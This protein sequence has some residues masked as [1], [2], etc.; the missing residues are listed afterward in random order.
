MLESS[1]QTPAHQT[2]EELIAFPD[3]WGRQLQRTPNHVAVVSAAGQ[4]T[5]RDLDHQSNA[6]ARALVSVGIQHGDRVGLCVDRSPEAIAAMLGIMKLG[7][8]FVPLDPDYPVDRLRYMVDDA[9]ITT[10]VG[11]R[12]YYES[13]GVP[14]I[15]Q[16]AAH[17]S[18][19][20][21]ICWVDC[22]PDQSDSNALG[23]NV[24]AARPSVSIAPSDLAYIMYTSGSTGKPKGVQI[25]HSA[26]ATY[27][28]A[29]IDVFRLT[30]NDRTLQFS[31][32]CFDIAIE[33]IFPP[34]LSGG[35]VV[36]RPKER[37]SHRNELSTLIDRFEITAVHIAA[38][39]WHQWVDLMVA[40]KERVPESLR[41]IIPTGEKVSVE[42][43]RRWQSICDH[44]VLFCNAYG[45]T[46]A[47]VTSTVYIPDESFDAANM[48]IG[49][50]LKRYTAHIL[51]NNLQPVAEG[52]TGHLFI[53]GPALALG[54]LNR[55]DLTAAAFVNV[56]IDGEK[57][58]LYR[59]GD[60]ARW[61]PDGN[62]DF[63]GRV[64]HQIKLGSYRIEPGEI[65]AA[66]DQAP[67]VLGSLVSFDEVDGK[68]FLVAY[69]AHG[70]HEVSANTIAT[71]LRSVLP[72]YMVPAR[73]VFL[74]K[75]PH[76]I[77]G[78]IDRR[79]LPPASEGVVARDESY[80]PPR[81]NLE[82]R[83]VELWQEVLNVPE[84]GI[85][86][87]FFLLGG[88]SL[89]VTQVVA[90]LTSDMD[91]DL[92]VRDFFANPTVASSARHLRELLGETTESY[93][94]DDIR[95]LRDR[96]PDVQASFFQSNGQS[97]YGVHYRPRGNKLGRGVV[98]CH[99][100]GHEY[101]RGYRNLQQ[102]AIQLCSAGFDVLRFDYASTGNSDGACAE[103]T[104]AEMQCNL[105]NARDFLIQQS[106]AEQIAVI[107]LRLGATIA[108]SMADGSFDQV[109]LWDPIVDVSEFIGTMD[110]WHRRQ[111]TELRRFS[112]IRVASDVDQSYGHAM[113]SEKRQ[114]LA[115]LQMPATGKNVSVVVSDQSL[116]SPVEQT[117]LASQTN[118]TRVA[119]VI[120]WD[121]Q[122][123]TESAFSSPESA[124]AI[125]RVLQREQG[126]GEASAA[127]R[128]AR[129]QTQP[130]QPELANPSPSD[131]K[132][133]IVFGNYDHLLGV[134]QPSTTTRHSD[135]AVILVTPGMLHH[136]GPFRLYVDVANDL[137][138]RGI[139]S[140][141]FDISGIGE[142][143]GVGAG[144][145]SIDR[146][147]DEISQAID[148][149]S[150]N[151]QLQKIVL[152]GLC[153]GA[154]DSLHAAV[155][156]D[157]VSAVVPMD[158]CGYRTRAYY[159][160][161][162]R[163]HHFHRILRPKKWWEVLQRLLNQDNTAPPSLQPGDDI[164]EFPSRETAVAE[165]SEL[166]DRKTRLHFVY[167][168]GVG[169]YY[170]YAQQFHDMFPELRGRDEVS[171]CFHPA[172][173][174]V[175][176]L[177]ED[178]ARLV[179]HIGSQIDQMAAH[180]GL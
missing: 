142:S 140:L 149:I 131:S 57:L 39:Y 155:R 52:E 15:D 119:D 64:D 83:L 170:S 98:I 145:R 66:I 176:Y 60:L 90:R 82:K 162:F 33:E 50:P 81:D 126:D 172:M 22:V 29:D 87:D 159:W 164:R 31:T 43:Y 146:A 12:C 35:C 95:A 51:D 59:T 92:P 157:R 128:P 118:V 25:Q 71:F 3:L 104:A 111:L 163:G 136:V 121:A 21:N 171:T 67:G 79:A 125:L 138:R 124:K 6:V 65:E 41:L 108:A 74:D 70:K 112:T 18:T 96:L 77:N 45:P 173:D 32:L 19:P 73:F 5:Y 99:S 38:A 80:V 106:G 42:H 85:H 102:L 94:D 36:V 156:D 113:S 14:L 101:A 28:F 7:A 152:F 13:I 49:K 55:P 150:A 56:Q 107:G 178:R 44:D 122:R 30:E 129:L 89:L 75:F 115:A 177:C 165:L 134:W 58:R 2:I 76:T 20:S 143:F 160:H 84:I 17:R 8:V 61:L 11:H 63:A 144:G 10:I 153:S 103:L 161:R 62:I 46:E 72:P 34:L 137:A 26:L 133:A 154:D 88:S 68:K 127:Q 110:Q 109:V 4:W 86:D 151:T 179:D 100:I 158:G 117:W 147:A 1:H 135:T 9:A 40:S 48:P 93:V 167:T 91:I 116:T 24:S 174:H 169:M 27:C 54:Y 78:K 168:G 180:S 148:W 69:V 141:R 166:A 139:A 130:A 97:L 47:T 53:G 114:S 175:A 123:Y 132:N 16:D 105:I 120:R 23:P 37:A